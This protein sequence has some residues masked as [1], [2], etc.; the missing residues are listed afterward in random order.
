MIARSQFL[1][2]AVKITFRAA[3]GDVSLTHDS[4]LHGEPST[5]SSFESTSL[6]VMS[7]MAR[8][9]FTRVFQ[10]TLFG[11]LP[12]IVRTASGNRFTTRFW[13]RY[14]PESSGDATA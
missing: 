5:V 4:N 3:G 1:N 11:S 14:G 2:Y 8:G 13:E 12:R 10:G 7:S 6:T 9:D